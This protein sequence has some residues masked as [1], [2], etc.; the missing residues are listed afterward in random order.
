MV[1]IIW[2]KRAFSQFERAIRFIR[3]EQGLTYAKIVYEK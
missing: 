2:T 1:K 3:N